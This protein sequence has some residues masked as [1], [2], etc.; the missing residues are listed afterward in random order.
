M[1]CGRSGSIGF[2][3]IRR[4]SLTG[5]CRT[6]AFCV[7]IRRMASAFKQFQSIFAVSQPQF[8]GLPGPPGAGF[9][10]RRGERRLPGL[11]PAPLLEQQAFQN[12]RSVVVAQPLRQRDDDALSLRSFSRAV[13]CGWLARRPQPVSARHG[14]PAGLSW[15]AHALRK[16]R[17]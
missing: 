7:F 4:P 2:S 14:S 3:H 11:A 9:H 12:V 10:I 16:G 6:D 17:N 15:P 13:P 1:G 8:F 5:S